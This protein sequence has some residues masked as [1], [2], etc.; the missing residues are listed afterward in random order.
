LGLDARPISILVTGT[1]NTS[2]DL[3]KGLARPPKDSFQIVKNGGVPA[4]RP[5]F[6]QKQTDANIILRSV[7]GNRVEPVVTNLEEARE[8]INHHPRA[9]IEDAHGRL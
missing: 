5:N 9:N 2:E 1:S 6:D 7:Q 4:F 8:V 3:T